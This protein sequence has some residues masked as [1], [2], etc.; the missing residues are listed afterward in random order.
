MSEEYQLPEK[1]SEDSVDE[2]GNKLSK[3]SVDDCRNVPS[4]A[5]DE[6]GKRHQCCCSEWKKRDKAQR[7][8]KERAEKKVTY[9]LVS[10]I[11]LT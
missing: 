5:F 2:N 1:W 3:R 7:V 8:Q 10:P 6:T 4:V 11:T 9:S